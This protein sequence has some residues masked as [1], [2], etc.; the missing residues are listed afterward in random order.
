MS[1]VSGREGAPS[2]KGKDFLTLLDVSRSEVEYLLE[3]AAALKAERAAGILR[4]TLAGKHVGLLFFKPSTRT[5]VSFE[6]AAREL[7]ASAL[8]L[9]ASELQLG[10]GESIEDTARVLSRYLHAVVIRTFKQSDLVAFAEAASIPVING[11]TDSF[12]PVQ[13]LADLLTIKE[14]FGQLGGVRLA[15]VGDGNNMAHSL[16][17][18]GAL[19]G[20]QVVVSCPQGYPPDEEVVRRAKEVASANG[21]SVELIPDPLQAVAGARVIYTDTWVSMGQEA[22][23]SERLAAFEGYQVNEALFARAADDAVFLHCL[24]AHKG[25]EVSESLF[26]SPRSLVFDQAENR[27]HVQKAL[28]ESLLA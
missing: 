19:T 17:A 20:M 21:G 25:E 22:E 9:N 13:V 18:G 4:S 27:L 11:L 28:L 24:P 23:R 8:Y 15:Y 26:E 14:R 5:R 2:L 10:R 12:H 6:V 3:R 16:M 1:D 7:G